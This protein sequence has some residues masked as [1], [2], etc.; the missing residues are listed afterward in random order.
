MYVFYN[1][2]VK[3]KHV[4]GKLTNPE[5]KSIFFFFF[6]FFLG[7][8]ILKVI[9]HMRLVVLNLGLAYARLALGPPILVGQTRKSLLNNPTPPFV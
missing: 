9:M 2:I 5:R 6:G 4:D 8:K 1:V 7:G 3:F